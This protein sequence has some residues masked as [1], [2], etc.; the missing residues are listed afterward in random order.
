MLPII[1]SCE[2]SGLRDMEHS[3]SP[4]LR[5]AVALQKAGFRHAHSMGQNFITDDGLI[6]EML[7][8]AE[9]TAEDCILE[10]GPGAGIMTAWLA[11]RCKRVVAL[12]LD[13]RLENVLAEVLSPYANVEVVF[14]DAL[15]ADLGAITRVA[16]GENSFRV[17][18]NLP[19]YITAEI[20]LRLLSAR[21]PMDSACLMVQREAAERM[22]A[23]VGEKNWCALSATVQYFARPEVLMDVPPEAFT[24][25]PHVFSQFIRLE[26]YREKPVRMQ[27]E[28]LFLR[29]VQC[30]FAMR[31]KTMANNLKAS[32]GISQEQALRV[33]EAVGADP[34]I[35]GE[36][37]HLYELASIS[38]ALADCFANG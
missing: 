23:A 34:K 10:I 36:A 4:S 27:D 37:L 19:Y 28:A 13:H 25:P 29:V 38:D 1:P 24:P 14:Q 17:V 22:M 21:L 3:F 33:L 6:E 32:F 30:A 18:A 2:R 9:V 16:F 31:R 12:E 20:V 15:K 26:M 8:A 35:R 5:A 11:Q 7:D